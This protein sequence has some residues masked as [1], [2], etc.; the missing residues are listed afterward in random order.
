MAQLQIGTTLASRGE[1]G[2][3]LLTTPG[4][5]D[6]YFSAGGLEVLLD[7]IDDSEP[8][9]KGAK[10]AKPKTEEQLAEEAAAAEALAQSEAEAAAAKSAAASAPAE[11]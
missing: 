2:S 4:G 5:V 6:P 10:P 1:D 7:F 9:K 11:A 8:P 3:L